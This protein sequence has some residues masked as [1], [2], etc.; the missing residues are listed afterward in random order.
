M[1]KQREIKMN[2]KKKSKNDKPSLWETI[3]ILWKIDRDMRKI[4]RRSRR[5]RK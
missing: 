4:E 2:P 1:K 5:K 3:K